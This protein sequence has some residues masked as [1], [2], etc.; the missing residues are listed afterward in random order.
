MTKVE[1]KPGQKTEG[2]LWF[3]APP[4]KANATKLEMKMGPAVVLLEEESPQIRATDVTDSDGKLAWYDRSSGARGDNGMLQRLT[5]V[6]MLV[7]LGCSGVA[8]GSTDP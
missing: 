8:P 4:G 1:L 7:L 5:A 3:V 6:V 2:R